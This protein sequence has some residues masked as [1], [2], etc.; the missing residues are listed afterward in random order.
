MTRIVTLSVAAVAVL[1]AAIGVA[2]GWPELRPLGERLDAE[3]RLMRCPPAE[4]EEQV[5]QLE[6]EVAALDTETRKLS[7]VAARRQPTEPYIVVDTRDNR[8]MVRQGDEVLLEAT[9]SA[10]SGRELVAGRRRWV[11]ETPKGIFRVTFKSRL[12]VWIKP[13]WAFYEEGEKPPGAQ[14]P[15]RFEEAVLGEYALG[16]GNGF[17]IHGTIY[18]RLLG[19]NVTHGCIRLGDEPLEQVF[20]IARV[21]TTIFI[22]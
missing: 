6:A 9:C 21:G 15:L 13:D 4:L 1:T 8:L 11:F 16:F 12:P 10:G 3:A 2:L 19:K 22:V 17:M 20:R 14:S 5:R 18:K 7:A